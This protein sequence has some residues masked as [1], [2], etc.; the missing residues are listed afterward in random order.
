MVEID[1]SAHIKYPSSTCNLKGAGFHRDANSGV[2]VIKAK[3]HQK[4][5]SLQSQPLIRFLM[6]IYIQ[7]EHPPANG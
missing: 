3:W 6:N 5:E 2:H 7:K 1:V 4:R